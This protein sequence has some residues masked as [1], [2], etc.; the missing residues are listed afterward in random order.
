MTKP[1]DG[2]AHSYKQLW[3]DTE[4]G[5][6]QR[7]AVWREIDRLFQP[8]DRVLDLGCGTGDDALHLAEL[9]VEVFGIDAAPKMVEVARNRGVK[10]ETLAIEDLHTLRGAFTGAISNFGALNCVA[11]I[12]FVAAHLARLLEP[13]GAVAICLMGRFCFTDWRHVAK[14][15]L[16][17]TSWR[18]L[19]IYYPTSRQIRSTFA[20]WFEFERR[21][22]IARGDHQLYIFRRRLEC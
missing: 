5:R 20:P 8:G 12:R 6:A 19:V 16:G 14:R 17:R 7:A 15:W 11:D 10:A 2:L 22:S 1:F 9:G 13:A 3:S 4:R 21:V 18:G